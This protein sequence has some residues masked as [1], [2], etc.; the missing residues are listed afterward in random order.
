MK[1]IRNKLLLITGTAILTGT[2]FASTALASSGMVNAQTTSNPNGPQKMIRLQLKNGTDSPLKLT[3]ASP[4]DLTAQVNSLL[5]TGFDADKQEIQIILKDN[6]KGIP[7]EELPFIFDRFRRGIDTQAIPGSGLGL[8][9]VHETLK[10]INGT[11]SV[12]SKVDI[13]TRFIIRLQ[14]IQR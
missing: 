3:A 4:E 12:E 13:G 10:R 2:L 11:I 1:L 9:I 6:G 14:P 5:E 8:A 7:E